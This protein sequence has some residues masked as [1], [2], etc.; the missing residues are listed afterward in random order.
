MQ[1]VATPFYL[2]WS[3]WAVIVAFLAIFLSQIPP[4]RTLL[5]RAKLELELYSKVSISH[6]LGNPNLQLH[7]IINNIGGRRV[8]V[9][10]INVSISRDSAPVVD[11]PAQTYLQNQNDQNTVLFT[12]FALEPKQEWAHITNFLNFFNRENEKEYQKI[13]G[14]LLSD[15]RVYKKT[16]KGK[17]NTENE[18]FYEHPD[19]LVQPVYQFFEKHFCWKAGEY[20]MNINVVTDSESANITKKYRFTIFESH[21]DTLTSIKDHFKY[22]GGT[23]WNPK[24]QTSVVLELTEA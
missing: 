15:F 18:D 7:L 13:E 22:G 17:E 21:T 11:F 2:D 12:T 5:K 20:T 23:Y 10:D 24:I 9:K 8:R 3:F 6:K 19:N 4:I 14:D 1:A 16:T